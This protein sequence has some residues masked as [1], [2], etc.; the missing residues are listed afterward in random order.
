M[1]TERKTRLQ[2]NWLTNSFD[3]NDFEK[4]AVHQLVQKFPT[5][6]ADRMFI[7]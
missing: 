1:Y 4:L 5:F 2:A 7:T 3:Q 6:Y